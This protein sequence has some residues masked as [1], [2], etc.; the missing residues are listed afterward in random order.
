VVDKEEAAT[1]G[2]ELIGRPASAADAKLGPPEDILNEVGGP[3]QWRVYPAPM[4]ALGNQRYVVKVSG[5]RITAVSKE[6]IDASGMELAKKYY[7]D[8]KA[9][10]KTPA[11]VQ[12][13]L[14]MGPPVV[15][16]RSEKTGRVA[17][18]FNALTLTGMGSPKLCRVRYDASGRCD[19]VDMVEIGGSAGGP[20]AL[21]GGVGDP[22]RPPLLGTGVGGFGR[23]NPVV[24]V[25]LPPCGARCLGAAAADAG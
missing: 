14:G 17:Q 2:N 20:S 10:G 12:Q 24:V 22:P 3:R 13:A 8:E 18:F 19:A 23:G 7:Y 21:G 9:K 6:E 4:N 11:E 5:G 25:C 1:V 15:T 16:V